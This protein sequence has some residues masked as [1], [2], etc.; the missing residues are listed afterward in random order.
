M[1]QRGFF[2][3]RLSGCSGAEHH[4]FYNL[5]SARRYMRERG[6]GIEDY[7]E[8]V[9]QGIERPLSEAGGSKYHAVANGAVPDIY[10]LYLGE[11]GAQQQTDPHPHACHKRFTLL[12]Q[13]EQFRQDWHGTAKIV[14]RNK[15]GRAGPGLHRFESTELLSNMGKILTEDDLDDLSRRNRKRS[16]EMEPGSA[17][18]LPQDWTRYLN[19]G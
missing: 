4:G 19:G 1:N 11:E 9:D 18:R 12:D 7:T 10:S 2:W 8:D 14:S 13:A 16:F 3:P 5:Q 6:F 17:E 15:C